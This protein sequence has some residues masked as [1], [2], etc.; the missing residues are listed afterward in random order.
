MFEIGVLCHKS[1]KEMKKRWVK[2]K[3]TSFWAERN[4]LQANDFVKWNH[5]LLFL[6][7][8]IYNYWLYILILLEY[9][10]LV[11]ILLQYCLFY[12]LVTYKK[13][14][15]T[16]FGPSFCRQLKN[17]PSK[18]SYWIHGFFIG[19]WNCFSLKKQN[20]LPYYVILCHTGVHRTFV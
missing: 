3:I 10:M 11:M 2:S 17:L 16:L 6:F 19:V 1:V 20:K 8:I 7:I 5:L 14:C 13:M 15:V 9:W 18:P 4:G 12:T